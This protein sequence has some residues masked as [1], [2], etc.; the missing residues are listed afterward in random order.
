MIEQVDFPDF[1]MTRE[2]SNTGKIVRFGAADI[3]RIAESGDTEVLI[4]TV[5]IKGTSSGVTGF[6][7][8][9]LQI[10]DDSGDPIIPK[11]STGTLTVC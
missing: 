9:A 2:V 10:D 1:G 11:I 7:I 5:T 3:H 8:N 6:D 4:A